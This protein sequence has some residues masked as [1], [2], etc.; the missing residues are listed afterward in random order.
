MEK[1]LYTIFV[2]VVEDSDGWERHDVLGRKEGDTTFT[3]E[4]RKSLV[5]QFVKTLHK[6]QILCDTYEDLEWLYY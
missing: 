4:E 1:K 5:E 6:G 3:I 2:G